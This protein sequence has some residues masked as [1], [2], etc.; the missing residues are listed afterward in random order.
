MTNPLIIASSILLVMSGVLHAGDPRPLRRALVQHGLVNDRIAPVV[1]RYLPILE[2]VAGVLGIIGAFTPSTSRRTIL[3]ALAA[4]L[5]LVFAIY[6]G[7]A[8]MR[9]RGD[10]KAVP[11]GCVG[12][13]KMTPLVVVRAALASGLIIVGLTTDSD[14]S[15]IAGFPIA[16]GLLAILF[17]LPAVD[18]RSRKTVR[19]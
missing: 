4:F 2:T 12:S 18:F 6:S 1:M 8:N 15:M 11:C 5:Y 3:V 14:M 13:D 19:E 7:L 16:A 10:D 9:V 17:Y